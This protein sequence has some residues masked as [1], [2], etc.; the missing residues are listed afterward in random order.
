[1]KESIELP[2]KIEMEKELFVAMLIRRG[3]IIPKVINV[4][5][6]DDFYRPEPQIIFNT[7]MRLYVQ[8]TPPNPLSII[9]ELRQA[10]KLE[11]VNH[12]YLY[13]LSDYAV[14]NAYAVMHA[15]IVKEKSNIAI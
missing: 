7:I 9:E 12:K 1:M 3:E 11:K 6:A 13:F 15:K 10:G 4:V 2:N 5:S 14:T 8:V